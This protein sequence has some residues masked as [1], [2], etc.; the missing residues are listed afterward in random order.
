MPKGKLTSR[1]SVLYCGFLFPQYVG[2]TI[3]SGTLSGLQLSFSHIIIKK[4]FL[5]TSDKISDHDLNA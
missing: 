5:G 4:N 3:P 1:V 2:N